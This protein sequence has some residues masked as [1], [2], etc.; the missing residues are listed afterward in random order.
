MKVKVPK[1]A[2]LTHFVLSPLG[3]IL[4]ASA[5]LLTVAGVGVFTYYYSHYSHVI[6]QKLRQGPFANTA[7]IFAAP[8]TLS[9]GDAITPA[10][11]ALELRRTGYNESERNAM[12]Y[13]RLRPNAIEIYPG[14]DS[15]FRRDPG[16]LKF[17]KD[18]ISQIISLADNADLYQYQLEPQLITNL[19][20]R[21][22]E[23]RR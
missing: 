23:K 20:D 10:E 7:K 14:P 21:N 12:G 18:K 16:L 8:R 13:Y 6:D 11:V 5:A 17:Q 3:K 19:F 15:Y 22:R 2:R 9:I 1:S 4:L